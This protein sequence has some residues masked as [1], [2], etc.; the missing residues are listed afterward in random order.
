MNTR[1]GRVFAVE[2]THTPHSCLAFIS[3]FADGRKFDSLFCP[4]LFLSRAT[5]EPRTPSRRFCSVSLVVLS[6]PFLFLFFCCSLSLLR[7]GKPMM[8]ENLIPFSCQS[9][10]FHVPQ[11]NPGPIT[12][13]LLCRSCSPFSSFLVSLFSLSLSLSCVLC[14]GKSMAA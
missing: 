13:I 6:L 1:E 8:G 14:S 10:F 12:S 9:L 5:A 4:K 11:L 2:V 7:S 3:F